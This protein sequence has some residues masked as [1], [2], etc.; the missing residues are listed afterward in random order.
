MF[1]GIS[2]YGTWTSSLTPTFRYWY[3]SL[4]ENTQTPIKSPV[5]TRIMLFVDH[6][7]GIVV[8]ISDYHKEL[9]ASVPGST[10]EIV[11]E[12]AASSLPGEAAKSG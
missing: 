3:A 12:Q 1:Q 7:C 11:L 4:L 9:S 2:T 8:S 6:L 5:S 10:L